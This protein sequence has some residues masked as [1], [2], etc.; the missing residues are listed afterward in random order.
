ML[1]KKKVYLHSSVRITRKEWAVSL[2][3]LSFIS[4]CP[5]FNILNRNEPSVSGNARSITTL[6]I[7]KTIILSHLETI[8]KIY[9]IKKYLQIP[10]IHILFNQF[11]SMW[12]RNQVPWYSCLLKITPSIQGSWGYVQNGWHISMMPWVQH[13]YH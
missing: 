5:H 10:L 4:S 7:R 1:E 11:L 2:L 8:V 12:Q 9:Y 6:M 13:I 3:Q